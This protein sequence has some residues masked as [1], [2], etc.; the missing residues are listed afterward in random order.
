MNRFFQAL[1]SRSRFL[2]EYLPGCSVRDEH[3]LRECWLM[4]LVVTHRGAARR[5]I[6]LTSSSCRDRAA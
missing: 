2:H 6:A 1:I 3:R 5:P 4:M